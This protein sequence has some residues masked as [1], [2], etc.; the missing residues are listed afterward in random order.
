MRVI[1]TAKAIEL[2]RE[3]LGSWF[4]RRVVGAVARRLR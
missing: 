4:E 3:P 2:G 1:E